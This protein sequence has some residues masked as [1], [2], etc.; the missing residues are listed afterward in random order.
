MG[1][2]RIYA[3]SKCGMQPTDDSADQSHAVPERPDAPLGTLI[4]RA[5][6]VPADQ[7]EDALEEGA[8]TGRRL[9]EI[10]LERDL[11]HEDDL[12]RLIAG[13]RGIQFLSASELR[14]DPDALALLPSQTA[15][16]CQA[17][18]VDVVDDVPIVAVADP[19]DAD[20]L[21]AIQRELGKEPRF[22]MATRSDIAAALS[23]AYATNNGTAE[24]ESFT[25]S[26]MA[27]VLS[28]QNAPAISPTPAGDGDT[29]QRAQGD[30]TAAQRI[31]AFDVVVRLTNGERIEVA[32]APEAT[33]AQTLAQD[34]I[35][36]LASSDATNWPLVAGRFIR[37]DA[38]VS[39]D[40]VER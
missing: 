3:D 30:D 40:I 33:E 4:F 16:A 18:P 35:R 14:P 19:T 7:L 2:A 38:I 21:E 25:Q 22:V 5:G 17:L 39:V 15:L 11:I 26:S 8:R 1:A 36:S 29:E 20:R 27:D 23:D 34:F 6:L 32:T 10:L 12:A 37:P 24:A 13:Q 31:A 9:G 28:F